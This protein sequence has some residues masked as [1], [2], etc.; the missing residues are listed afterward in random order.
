MQAHIPN[1]VATGDVTAPRTLTFDEIRAR[2]A[3]HYAAEQAC[4][5]PAAVACD[6][7]DTLREALGQM[8]REERGELVD[9]IRALIADM[10]ALSWQEFSAALAQPAT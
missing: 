6:A 5:T 4:N 9:E 1:A 7:L 8:S 2:V 10:A 3:A